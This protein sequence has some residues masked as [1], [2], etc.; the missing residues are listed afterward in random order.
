[1]SDLAY[2]LTG[3][4]DLYRGDGRGPFASVNFVT[5][6]DGFTLRD[7]VSYDEKH[8]ASNGEE[9]RDG[10]DDNRSWNCGAEGNTDDPAIIELRGRQMRNLLA[11][12]ALSQGVPMISHGDELG[13]TQNGNNNAYCQDSELSWM[14]WEH[15]DPRLVEFTR[16][17]LELR[18]S[19]SVLRRKKFFSGQVGRGQNRKDL[20]W[21]RTD[22][23]EMSDHSW[24]NQNLLSIG[25]L[26]N[27]EQINDRSPRGEPISG[28]TLLILLHAHWHRANWRLPLGWGQV[29]EVILDTAQPEEKAGSRRCAGGE[30]LPVTPRSLVALRKV[31]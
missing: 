12:V 17:L 24:K 19:Q 10:T 4:S 14:D 21:F 26:L 29:W 20:V 15:C 22:G 11:T 31:S 23:Q 27:G 3:S 9:N 8:N 1:V 28:D 16:R 25:M 5:C 7:L 30:T 2:R 13:R 18:R 6:H